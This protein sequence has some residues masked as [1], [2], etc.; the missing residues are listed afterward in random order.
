MENVKVCEISAPATATKPSFKQ[1]AFRAVVAAS[2]AANALVINAFAVDGESSSST[3]SYSTI[4][5]ALKSGLVECVNGVIDVAVAIIPVG[6][7]IYGIGFCVTAVKKMF[8]K[9]AK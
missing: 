1:K 8:N 4:G 7:G 6:I 2:M 9:V 3:V 5:D